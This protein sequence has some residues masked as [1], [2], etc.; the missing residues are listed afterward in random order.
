MSKYRLIQKKRIMTK[1][2]NNT[3]IIKSII[4]AMMILIFSGLFL[5]YSQAQTLDLTFTEPLCN[6][7]AN[8][9]ITASWTGG[10]P[11]YQYRLYDGDPLDF[12]TTMLNSSGVVAVDN[13]TFPVSLAAGLY[14]VVSEHNIGGGFSRITKSIT[15]TE[16]TP[17]SNATITILKEMSCVG[18]NDAELQANISDGTPPYDYLWNDGQTTPIATGLGPGTY[19]VTITDANGCGGSDQIGTKFYTPSVTPLDGGNIGSDQTICED[20]DVA[21]FTSSAVASGGS[22]SYTYTWQYS[23]TSTTPGDA[24]WTDIPASDSETWDFGVLTTTTNFVRRA[25]DATC[26]T[27]YSNVVTV[28]VQ[29]K[30]TAPTGINITNNNTCQGTDK[31]LTVIGGSLGEGATWQWYS[32]SC[33]GTSVGS[34]NSVTVDPAVDTDYFVRAEGTCN[35]TACVTGTVVVLEPSASPTGA[36]SSDNNFC[37]GSLANITLSYTGGTLGD[38]ATAEWYDDAGLTNNIGSGQNLSI[39]APATTT[40]YYVRFEGTCNNT[41]DVSTTVNVLQLST[42]PA[43]AGSSDN[44]FCSGTLANITLSYTGGTLGD[45]ATAEWYDD[46]GLTNNIGSGQNLSIPAPATT[47]TYYVRF[48]SACNNTL[49]VSTTVNVLQ[50]ST[51][52]TGAGSSDNNFCVGTV[53][54]ITLSYMGG[55]LGDGATA[56]WYDDAALTNNI[57]TGNN[58][59]IAAPATTTTYYVRFESACN[60]TLDV[61]TTV[62]VLQESTAPTGASSSA[63]NFCLGSVANITLSYTGG[64]L[65]DGA[66]AEW[67]SDALLTNNIGTGQNLSIPAPAVTTTYYVR[68]ESSCNNTLDVSTTVTVLQESTAPT[69][70]SSSDNNFCVGTVPNITLSYAGGSLGDG[71][72]AEWYDDAGLTNNIGSGQN[73]SIAAP[74]TTT[75]YYVRFEGTCNNTADVSTTV[76]VLQESTAPTSASSSDNNFCVGTIANITL[77]YTGGTLGN[78]ASAEWYD[79]ATLT[80][81]IGSGQNLSIPAPATTTT[82][83]VRFEGTC[84]NTADVSTTV[85][86]Q[87]ESTAPTSAASSA[88]SFCAGSIANI[89]LSY[90][91]GSLGNGAIAEWYDDAA[92]TNNIGAGQ[93]LTIAAPLNTTTYYVRF[94]GNCNL[95]SAVNVTVNVLELSTNPA[96]ISITNDNTCEGTGKTLT[97]S[98]GSLGSA[99]SWQWYTG[100]CGGTSIGSG[101]SI[102]VDPANDTQ[103][104]VRAEGTC[105]ITTCATNTV[106]VSQPSVAPTGASSSDNNFC[107]GS[108][109]NITLSYAG[110]SLGDGASAEWYDD[111]ALT[112]NIGSGQNLSIPAPAT[113]TT[114]YVR[115]EGTC[116][117]TV[118][119]STTVTVLQQSVAPTG[120]GSSD[121]NFCEGTVANITLSYTGGTLGDGA[122]AEWYTDAAFT[123]NIGSGQNLSIP[124]PISTTTYYVRFEGTCNTTADVSTSVTVLQESTAP[125]GASSSDNNFCVGTVANITLS[126]T[127]GSLGNGASAEWYDDAALT[128]NIGSGQNLSIAAPVTTTTYYVRFEGTCNN[129]I[130]VST[131]VTVQQESIAPISASSSDNNFCVGTIANITLSYTGG[132]LGNGASAEWYDDAALTNNIGSGQNLSIPAPV[133]TTTYYVRFEGTCNNTAD[134]STTVT[135]L[136]ESTA[137]TAA[138]SSDNNFCVGTLA[139]ITLSYT[140]GN[141]GTGAT[142]QWYDDATLTNNIGSGQNLSI[143]APA[144]TTTYYVRFEGTCNNTA[145]ISTTVTVQQESAAPATVSSSVNDYCVG[146][147]ANI[148]LSYTGGSLGDGATAEWYDDAALTSNIGS[149]NNLTIAAPGI[150]TTYYVRFEGTCNITAPESVTVN[151]KQESTDPAGASSSDNNF[152]VGTVADITLSYTGGSLGDG[153]SAQW[154][155]DAALTSNIGTGQDLVIA[156]PANTTTYYVRFEGD[157]N[158]TAV[159]STTVNVLQESTPPDAATSSDD[160]FCEGTVANITLSYTGGTL[161]N[162]ATAQWYS[163]AAFTNNVGMGQDLVIPAPAVTTTYYVRFEGACNN[164]TAANVTVNV[165]LESVAPLSAG[166]SANDFCEGSVS[167]ITLSYSGGTL[168]DGATAQWYTDAA[169]TNNIGSGQN[170]VITAPL[171]TTTYYVRFEGTCNTTADEQVTVNV[172]QNPVATINPVNGCTDQVLSLNGAPFGGSFTYISHEWTGPGAANLSATNVVNPEFLTATAGAY[173]LYYTVTDDNGCLGYDTATIN[174]TQGPIVNAGPNDTICHGDSYPITGATASDASQLTWSSSGDGVFDDENILAPVYTPGIN[175][176]STGK[177]TLYLTAD[178]FGACNPVIDSLELVIPPELEASIGTLPPFSIS[179]STEITVC[180]STDDH[181]VIQDLGYY[182][183]APDGQ[184]IVTLKRAPMEYDFF[185]FCNFGSDVDNL[186]FSSNT[187]LYPDTLDVCSETPPLTGTHAITGDWSK[188]YGRNPAEG[189]WAIMVK[190]TAQNRGGIDGAIIHASITFTDIADATGLPTSVV[191]DS[192]VINEP[193]LEP[194]TTTYAIP[195]GLSVSCYNSCDAKAVVNVVGGVGPYTYSWDDAGIPANDTVDLCRGTYTVTVTDAIGC[196]TVATVEVT[197]PDELIFN[198]VTFTDTLSCNGDTTASINISASGGTGAISYSID[199]GV[200][201]QA[202][203]LFENLPAGTYQIQIVDVNG[204]TR[205]TSITIAAP[206]PIIYSTTADTIYCNGDKGGIHFTANGGTPPYTYSIDSAQNFFVTADTIG[207]EPDTYYTFVSDANGCTVAGDTITLLEPLAITIDSIAFADTLSCFGDSTSITISANGGTGNLDYSIDD[208]INY[209]A[210]S[211][212]SMQPAATYITVVRDENGCMF[213][214][215]TLN[216]IEPAPLEFSAI[217]LT[218]NLCAEDTSGTIKIGVTGGRDPYQYSIDGGGTLFADSAFIDLAPG[219]YPVF[220]TDAGG[221]TRDTIVE[222]LSPDSI[223][224][225]SIE[226]TNISCNGDTDGSILISATGGNIPYTYKLFNNGMAIDSLVSDTSALF[227]TLTIGKYLVQ[228]ND[229]NACGPIWSDTI[230][231][232]EPDPL[233]YDS[234]EFSEFICS[235]NPDGFIHMYISGGTE[236]YNFLIDGTPTTDSITGLAGG[237]YTV[238]ISDAGGCSLTDTTLTITQSAIINID[239]IYLYDVS[240]AGGSDGAI[241]IEASGGSGSLTYSIENVEGITYSLTDSFDNLFADAYKVTVMDSIGCQLPGRIVNI[242]QPDSIKATFTVEPYVDEDTKGSIIVHA[243]GGNPPYLYS[244]DEGV[245]LQS[246]SVFTDL[247]IGLYTITIV[248]TKGCTSEFM[249]TVSESDMISV[250]IIAVQ[251]V[252]CPD[253][254]DGYAIFAITD[255]E[256]EYPVKTVVINRDSGDTIMDVNLN[257]VEFNFGPSP[258]GRYEIFMTDAND[259]EF[260]TIFEIG[261]PDPI[262]ANLTVVDANCENHPQ[263]EIIINNYFGGTPEYNAQLTNSLNEDFSQS[264]PRV[265]SNLNNDEYFLRITDGNGCITDTTISVGFINPFQA[266]LGESGDGRCYNSDENLNQ[267]DY[268]IIADSINTIYIWTNSDGFVLDTVKELGVKV[269]ETETYFL[270]IKDTA[271]NCISTDSVTVKLK[272]QT[273]LNIVLDTLYSSLEATWEIEVEANTDSFASYEWTPVE[274]LDDPSIMEPNLT[275]VESQEYRLEAVDINNCQSFDILT[276]ILVDD[277]TI[278][279]GFTPNDDGHN[280]YWHI[281]NAEGYPN[282]QVD[283]FNRWGERIFSTGNYDNVSNVWDGTRNGKPVPVG[284]YYYVIKKDAESDGITGTVTLIR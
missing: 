194:Y 73:L 129:T 30:S 85:T 50:S 163:D 135:V 148:T 96:G 40:T 60:N 4:R 270:T 2:E 198:S 214:G 31:T 107:A 139:N 80:N 67:Y 268:S 251:D 281:D 257:S 159:V 210:D 76:T 175:D 190:D 264:A 13:Y 69:S 78:G 11:N 197:A 127:G 250:Q 249:V 75:T 111:A 193:I 267:N 271:L 6:G 199:G 283:V 106:Q 118:D 170:L 273:P 269:V 191:F 201:F 178:G 92:L 54:N 125:T 176:L 259:R 240:C 19:T 241:R 154:Y 59:T 99:A 134:V 51:A 242:D 161:G 58:L 158:T 284:T 91:G 10:S 64:T 29:A 55:T 113:T 157:C 109:G 141:L 15:V 226:I 138:S 9:T 105:N 165:L 168:G 8:G 48:E 244:I 166:S 277:I 188:I 20:A 52:P 196:S 171:S 82:Y 72:T 142:A 98:G 33:G 46:A 1:N 254:T 77:S 179:A 237:S 132:T 150:T 278:Y 122:T 83:Y 221:C 208:G 215:D 231:V 88:N 74:A 202:G 117:N 164:T 25:V 152:C 32:G 184:T 276:V 137:P 86:V 260:T 180:L 61:S 256:V 65:G 156:A 136:Q 233:M 263:G 211:L 212:F 16:P 144:T 112:N 167:D 169:F 261:Q 200:N 143:P 265:Y 41:L 26:G 128:N 147:E 17:M 38:G 14:F 255:S 252:S 101:S 36:S 121:N 27:V 219:N 90:S 120:A 213:Y 62:T 12:G 108:I 247:D 182:L 181:Q 47:T 229:V 104:W 230:E 70:A 248:D 246:D 66:T 146:T 71:A 22:Q 220:I 131:T 28:T 89:T 93:N 183:V 236:P 119:V 253:G 116:N 151:V 39:P 206:S 84:N 280:D 95:T 35:T 3:S 153:A 258:A 187:I 7:D 222:I 100:S 223:R 42:A 81:N 23:T 216:I 225:D 103:Y 24:S 192:D 173:E 243:T 21:A 218:H 217:D 235:G 239:S 68:F 204:C 275:V 282:C 185:G 115:F 174:I 189:G 274:G 195:G 232:N 234:I 172:Y 45:G 279:S 209:Q 130:D 5:N 145:D 44:N 37:V 94:E 126:Y 133:T 238:S 207:L 102:N 203:G 34:G 228:I 272:P 162:G 124:A 49:D 177:V 79:D 186:C 63:T 114:Y 262:G 57:G 123:N 97:V 205:D 160:N 43:S 87:Q 227:D 266:I 155:D 149:G 245:T 53:P 56:E 18:A 110:G 224:I 140:G